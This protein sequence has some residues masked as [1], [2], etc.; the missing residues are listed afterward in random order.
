MDI[1]SHF[2][3]AISTTN[4]VLPGGDPMDLG[5]GQAHATLTIAKHFRQ[6]NNNFCIYY[7]GANYYMGN[8]SKA[9]QKTMLRKMIIHEKQ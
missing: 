2:L 1:F 7:G 8:C 9:N 3:D 4:P 6:I 5:I